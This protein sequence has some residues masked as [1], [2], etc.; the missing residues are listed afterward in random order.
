M[1]ADLHGLDPELR[2]RVLGIAARLGVEPDRLLVTD[3]PSPGEARKV[4]MARMLADP[5]TV[6]VLDE[7]TNH[8]DIPSI[9]ALEDA[10]AD[11]PGTLLLV[12]HDERLAGAVTTRV[13][14][15]TD[16]TAGT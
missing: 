14:S 5:A 3:D 8:L 10:L 13:W 9:E 4:A 2:G 1:V 7:P 11:W 15:V 6:V 16:G 12:T